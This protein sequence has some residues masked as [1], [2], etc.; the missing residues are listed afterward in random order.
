MVLMLSALMT[1]II[2]PQIYHDYFMLGGALVWAIG[3]TLEVVADAQLAKF[4]KNKKSGEIMQRGLWRY[5]RH[6]NYFGEVLLWWGIW[7]I[8][9]PT[10]YW[11]LTLITPVTITFL[12][13][14]VSGVPMAEERYQDNPEFQAYAKRTN[15]FIPW[16]PKSN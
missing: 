7:L 10:P 5:S 8:T 4:V 14:K 2:Y 12:I 6:P 11:W 3:L 1:T 9:L 13:L 16:R 15:V